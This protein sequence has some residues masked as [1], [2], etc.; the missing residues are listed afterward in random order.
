MRLLVGAL[1]VAG[2]LGGSAHAQDAATPPTS[3]PAPPDQES[4]P[5][6][7]PEVGRQVAPMSL[8]NLSL[9]LGFEGSYEERTVKSRSPA[10]PLP[11]TRQINKARR[12]EE[13]L[14][15]QASGNIGGEDVVLFDVGADMGLSQEWY[16]EQGQW[17]NRNHDPHGD[18]LEYD[19][20]MTALPRGKIS[21]DGYAQKLDSRVPRMFLPSLDRTLERYGGDVLINDA[22]FPMR[23]SFEH[24]DEE[25]NSRVGRTSDNE[26]RAQDSFRYEGAWQISRRQSLRLEYE[27]NDRHEQYA[28]SPSRFD[29]RRNYLALNHVW[30]LGEDEKSSWENLIRW[31]DET[32]DLGRDNL[33]LASRLR[34]Q[35]T[36]KLA[37]NYALQHLQDHF[38]RLETETDRAEAGVTYQFDQALSATLQGY[39]FEQRAN[40]SAD[41][42]ELG[43]LAN[44]TYSKDNDLGRLSANLS[45]NHTNTESRHGNNR[46]IVIGEAVTLV[47]PLPSFL[48]HTDIDLFSIV[49]TDATRLRTYLPGRDYLPVR[50][51]RYTSLQRLPLGAIADHQTVVASYTYDVRDDYGVQRD[52]VDLRIQQDFKFGLSPY[53]A[54]SLQDEDID[55][56]RFLS[57]RERDINRQR[58]GATYRR[59]RWSMGLEYEY[60]DDAIDPYQAVHGNG[61][62]ILFQTA[63]HQLD[64]K[65]TASR[66][67]FDGACDLAAHDTTLVDTGVTYRSLLARDLEANASAMYRYEDDSLYGVTHGVDLT[68]AVD[69]RIGR[70]TLRFEAE[71]DMLHLPGSADD[72]FGFWIKLKR[73]IPVIGGKTQ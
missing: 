21:A 23:L 38:Q 39:G 22:A 5:A 72:S 11:S 47:D 26:K 64:G 59:P 35:H 65:L 25:L 20:R 43:S 53:Y 14:G 42:R 2:C 48:A 56:D 10:F 67:W 1:A 27:Y 40:E 45:Y 17:P 34:L 63:A 28:G 8:E 12:F 13:T 62:L 18:L 51:G 69:W 37:T 60:N 66:F 71:Y 15:L 31:Q 70:F 36:D 44:L 73:E 46:G 68:A 52:R 3:Q 4:R 61:D 9:E 54:A 49:V 55:R 58:L 33:E 7:P 57:F 50:V 24:L 30:R 29:T 41:Y 16:S 6:G 32:G 19:L